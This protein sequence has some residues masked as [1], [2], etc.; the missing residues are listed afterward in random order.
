MRDE[1]FLW[2]FTSAESAKQKVKV[3]KHTGIDDANRYT[4]L[5]TFDVSKRCF[6]YTRVTNC[7]TFSLIMLRTAVPIVWRM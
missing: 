4:I 3:T 7:R 1:L 6:S 5:G 2:S